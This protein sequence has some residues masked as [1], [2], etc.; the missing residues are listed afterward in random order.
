LG[1]ILAAGLL[2][3]LVSGSWLPV[4]A[5]A[6]LSGDAQGLSTSLD[7]TE[8]ATN[9]VHLPLVMRSFPATPSTPS[10]FG[11]HVRSLA[12]PAVLSKAVAT[13]ADWVRIDAFHWDLIEPSWHNPPVYNWSVVDDASLTAARQNGMEVIAVILYAP[14]WAQ[15]VPGSECGPFQ[16]EAF[17]DFARFLA[18]LVSR[19]SQPPY[20]IRY[21]ELGNEPDAPIFYDRYG[22]GCW[23]QPGDPYFGGRYY[24]K[25][26]KVAYPAIKAADPQAQVL[27]GGLLMD[28]DPNNPPAGKDCTMSKFLEGILL[29][30][31]GDSFDLANFHAYTYW[32]FGRGLG[33]M[34]NA[35]WPGSVTAVPEKVR[36]LR[37][38]LAQYGYGNRVL[39]NTEA[40]L[41]CY[42]TENNGPPDPRCID[43][44][45]VFVPRSYVDALVLGLKAHTHYTL[46]DDGWYNT[47]LLRPDLTPRPAYQ[48][49]LAASSL[50]SN[51]TYL[52]PASGYRP[53]I[54]GYSF[55]RFNSAQQID[56]I[57][58][59]DG[60]NQNV[61]LPGGA[62]AYDRFGSLIPPGTIPVNYSP[63]Y[64]LKP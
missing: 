19:Y 4:Q 3:G 6:H 53:E 25:M 23:G 64:V 14:P 13:G 41:L 45:S 38:V 31:G 22:Y 47:G 18:A 21:W 5:E 39:V 29:A 56:V 60:S 44:Q 2:G 40:A 17:D 48:A 1:L 59:K 49:Y 34:G 46:V 37:S 11:V 58:S 32:D 50:L 42:P 54:E 61:T 9:T 15:S 30:G 55:R 8:P 28:C 57:W 33:Y 51:A 20:N 52:G 62:T 27:L 63:V 24:G 12:Q 43:T 36:F 16:E 7:L 26:L 35:N 10:V